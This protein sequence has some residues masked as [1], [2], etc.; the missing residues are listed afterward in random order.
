M[1]FRFS[2]QLV[3][4]MAIVCS[5]ATLTLFS[6]G[7]WAQAPSPLPA[8]SSP[9]SVAEKEADALYAAQ[10]WPEALKAYEA[11]AAANPKD[12]RAWLQIG[13][14]LF[15]TRKHAQAVEMFAKAE[16]NGF[17]PP[18]LPPFRQA[19]S[20]ARAGEK[21]KAFVALNRSVDAGFA[22]LQALRNIPDF[23]A[24]REDPRFAGVLARANENGKPCLKDP[25]YHVFDFWIGEWNVTNSGSPHGPGDATNE[26]HPIL[27]HC[28][29]LENWA[30]PGGGDGKGVHTY[31]AAAKQW[32]QFWVTSTGS[33]VKFTGEFK[34]GEM[35]YFNETTLPSGQ[36]AKRRT[37]IYPL[38]PGHVRQFGEQTTD[39]GKTWTV[40]YDLDYVLKSNAPQPKGTP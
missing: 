18:F 4:K 32:E 40:L 16:A 11:I 6:S 27:D 1:N 21:D 19:R 2:S 8:A 14:V 5:V 34:D 30:P 13:T 31:N 36:V 10:K 7:A 28:A 17:Q 39:S 37:R 12:A 3:R 26:I 9:Q 25:A 33:V 24:L 15:E 35:Q 29:L 20:W 23:A 22:N 38:G